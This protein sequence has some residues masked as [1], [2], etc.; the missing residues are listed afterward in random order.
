MPEAEANRQRCSFTAAKPSA[1]TLKDTAASLPAMQ[2]NHFKLRRTSLALSLL[3]QLLPVTTV[4]MA[5]ADYNQPT[6]AGLAIGAGRSSL[7]E[8]DKIQRF[9]QNF[10]NPGSGDGTGDARA[11]LK[12]ELDRISTSPEKAGPPVFE[13]PVP[14]RKKAVSP[15]QAVETATPQPHKQPVRQIDPELDRILGRL[16]LMRFRGTQP[17]DAGPKAVH[18]LLQSG[19][20]AGVIFKGDNI[21]SKA[22]LKEL[23]KFLG[24]AVPGGKPLLAIRETGSGSNNFPAK[25]FE[26]FPE[27]K[28]IAAK[29]EP[30]YAYSTY[31]SMGAAMAALGFNMNFGPA[32][33][34]PGAGKLAASFGGDPL[35]AGVFAKTFILGHR[36]AGLIAVPVVDG[37]DLSVRSLKS[38]LVPYPAI[39][40]AAVMTEEIEPFAPYQ[41]L[42][43]GARFCFVT[44]ASLNEAS[45]AAG[46]FNRACDA[47][48]L[49]GGTESP[50]AIRDALAQGV[51]EA[52]Q[53]H[54]LSLEALNASAQRVLALKSSLVSVPE[55][56]SART[57]RTP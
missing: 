52:M 49:D 47:L 4:P 17:S 21:Q 55:S 39:P 5:F 57:A 54:E 18:T 9:A 16:L 32:L 3:V 27:E 25:D 26:Q 28:D 51:V 7:K 50:L 20:I 10:D 46:N 37:S 40:I 19:L 11:R 8:E 23:V 14:V 53:H 35:Q 44:L 48:I 12:Q 2:K 34:L 45:D 30:E 31:R 41:G 6:A 29:G 15:A 56:S 38:L 36:E 1:N 22:Q 42:V 24:Q 33:G 43:R 13:P